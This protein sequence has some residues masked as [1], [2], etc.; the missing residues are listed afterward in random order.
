MQ[1]YMSDRNRERIVEFKAIACDE[2]LADD[3]V[4][5]Y[6][7]WAKGKIDVALNYYFNRIEKGRP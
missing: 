5:T 4:R 7:T 6:L 2:G 3:E 1:C